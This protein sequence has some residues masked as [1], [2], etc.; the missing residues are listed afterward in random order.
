MDWLQEN[1]EAAGGTVQ[2]L[3]LM[4]GGAIPFIESYGASFVG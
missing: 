2:A 4:L 3:F 1:V